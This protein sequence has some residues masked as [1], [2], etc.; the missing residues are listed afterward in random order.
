MTDVYSVKGLLD[1]HLAAI[2]MTVESSMNG[3]GIVF[4]MYLAYLPR[5]LFIGSQYRGVLC[6]TERL[7]NNWRG[8]VG[9]FFEECEEK[10]I[11]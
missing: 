1:K 10:L 5:D 8:S 9:I 6:Y 4:P 3:P 11:R 7:S 2:T